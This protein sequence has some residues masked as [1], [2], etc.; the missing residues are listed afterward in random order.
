MDFTLEERSAEPAL[1]DL[2]A[3]VLTQIPAGQSGFINRRRDNSHYLF[4]RLDE[5]RF[6]FIRYD[7]TFSGTTYILNADGSLLEAYKALGVGA[8]VPVSP[9]AP[10]TL[11]AML[12][13][14]VSGEVQPF[15]YEAF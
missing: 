2:L 6:R 7:A 14:M 8:K 5:G 15:L 10:E 1:A 3:E 4:E 11:R 13:D 9:P 12:L